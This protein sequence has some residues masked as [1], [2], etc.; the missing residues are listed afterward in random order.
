M[1]VLDFVSK[2]NFSLADVRGE[3]TADHLWCV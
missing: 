3:Y 1:T 2:S